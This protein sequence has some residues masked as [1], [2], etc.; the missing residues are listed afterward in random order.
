VIRLGIVTPVGF[1]L[2]FVFARNATPLKIEVM[3]SSMLLISSLGKIAILALSDS[4]LAMYG[5]GGIPHAG[6]GTAAVVTM[7]GGVS[8]KTVSSIA[9]YQ[10]LLKEADTALYRAKREGRNRVAG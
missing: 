6:S 4:P 1:L 8:S 10:E 2:A 3:G 7:S 9:E 5:H